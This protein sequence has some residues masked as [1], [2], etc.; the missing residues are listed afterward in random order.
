MTSE[1]FAK[2]MFLTDI[3][4]EEDFEY[5]TWESLPQNYKDEYLEEANYWINNE[6][7]DNWPI[8]FLEKN[9]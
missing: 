4:L 3:N 8:H 1:E 7:Y 5:K 9:K 6:P 2:K